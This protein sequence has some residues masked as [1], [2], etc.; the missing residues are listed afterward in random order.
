METFVLHFSM[1]D[2]GI[3][4]MERPRL[5]A[6][7]RFGLGPL[8]AYVPVAMER[9]RLRAWKQSPGSRERRCDHVAMERPRLR[10]WKQLLD[11]GLAK[12]DPVAMER[13]RLRAWKLEDDN[14][15][16]APPD[17]VAM[18][19][20]RLRAWKLRPLP[21]DERR[22]SRRNGTPTAQG[23]ETPSHSAQSSRL[24][25]SQWNARGSGHGNSLS[26]TSRTKSASRNGTP[27]AQGMET[28]P[29]G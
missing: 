9:P 22:G 15:H 6:W 2:D 26:R 27:A 21:Q 10:A 23:M 1:I 24:G 4:A 8:V 17:E 5:R 3:V 18:E 19:R 29:R 11:F 12:V 28:R 20:P 7:K 25:R 13:P 14:V 16:D